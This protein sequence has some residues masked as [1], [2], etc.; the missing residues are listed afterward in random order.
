MSKI[1]QKYSPVLI[2]LFLIITALLTGCFNDINKETPNISRGLIAHYTFDK[3]NGHTAKDS[4]EY[5]INGTIYG[6]NWTQGKING[7]LNFDGINDYVQIPDN[8]SPPPEHYKD[9]DQGTISFWFKSDYIP[10]KNAVAPLLHYGKQKPCNVINNANGGLIIELGHDPLHNQSKRIYFT[11]F[12]NG[13]ELYPSLCF[14]SRKN[15]RENEWHHFVV[16]VG[17]YN[18]IRYNTGYL[19][20]GEIFDRHYNFANAFTAEFFKDAVMHESLFLGKGFWNKEVHYF[21]GKIDDLRIYDRPLTTEEVVLLYN[22][23]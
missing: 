1:K 7:A 16:V 5:D 2:S 19:D 6:A 4:S 11:F 3:E 21:D 13:C 14:D 18:N 9:I 23:K 15:I 8:Q 17:Y 22:L 10:T 12:S 20:G